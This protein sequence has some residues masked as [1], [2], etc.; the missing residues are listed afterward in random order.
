M[1]RQQ[2]QSC[3]VGQLCN[4]LEKVVE[5]GYGGNECEHAVTIMFE[6]LARQVVPYSERHRLSFTLPMMPPGDEN[7]YAHLLTRATEL[8]DFAESNPAAYGRK[9]RGAPLIFPFIAT[10]G[11]SG[12]VY[13]L[14][15]HVARL[16]PNV[17]L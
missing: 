2:E 1:T 10:L 13:L 15:F 17:L 16:A 5:R 8:L 3:L 7:T 4:S 14:A 12:G 11:V 6:D 9:P